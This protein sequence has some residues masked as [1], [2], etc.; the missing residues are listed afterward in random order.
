MS[1]KAAAGGAATATASGDDR[2][3]KKLG[4]GPTRKYNKDVIE[5]Q[6]W[7][8]Y[9]KEGLTTADRATITFLTNK[10]GVH[11]MPVI[12]TFSEPAEPDYEE[13]V[14]GM[15]EP[16][17]TR[18]NTSNRRLKQEYV[19]ELNDTIRHQA[20]ADLAHRKLM[21]TYETNQQLGWI[22]LRNNV[23]ASKLK[24]IRT[25]L[26]ETENCQEVFA[27]L[28]EFTEDESALSANLEKRRLEA[29]A[30][31]FYFNPRGK[32]SG[33]LSEW[34]SKFEEY[35]SQANLDEASTLR[36]IRQQFTGITYTAEDGIKRPLFD[37]M[38]IEGL[39]EDK[40]YDTLK[41]L[42]LQEWSKYII[43]VESH[44][45]KV[46]QV[47]TAVCKQVEVDDTAHALAY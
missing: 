21:E 7:K 41:P 26:N 15:A 4:F 31:A 34:F 38:A 9:L 16:D 33:A 28:L 19:K 18:L 29:R 37:M 39:A 42:L 22:W 14:E 35:V 10:S 2:K 20:T 5:L 30:M 27:N 43:T 46:S 40:D 24:T 44:G 45:G 47:L 32:H 23:N 12:T 36:K 25:A 1:L 8:D 11:D 13:D 3:A 17:R 6:Q